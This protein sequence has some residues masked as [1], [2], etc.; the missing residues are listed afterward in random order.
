MPSIAQ[1]IRRRSR[2]TTFKHKEA[3]LKGTGSE[4]I[5]RLQE[6][7]VPAARP[8]WVVPQP[9]L[10]TGGV[11]HSGSRSWLSVGGSSDSSTPQRQEK[12]SQRNGG[13]SV[14]SSVAVVRRA[15]M[16]QR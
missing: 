14:E 3:G 7:R 13:P 16:Q 10:P 12:R 4:R 9:Q 5:Y 15:E 2:Q 8:T 1:C 6:S 11:Q